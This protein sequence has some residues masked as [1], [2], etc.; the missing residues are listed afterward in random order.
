MLLGFQQHNERLP[1]HRSDARCGMTGMGRL[2]SGGRADRCRKCD[3]VLARLVQGHRDE[4]RLGCHR[5]LSPEN[6]DRPRDLAGPQAIE[7]MA[8]VSLMPVGGV[9]A[10]VIFL[11]HALAR[12]H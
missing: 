11:G 8:R 12:Y 2:A 9:R 3:L 4:P 1:R 7:R 6:L 5:P 10:A